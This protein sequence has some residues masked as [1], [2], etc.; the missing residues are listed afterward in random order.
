LTRA[1]AVEDMEIITAGYFSPTAFTHL[2]SGKD[3][4]CH[5]EF[6]HITR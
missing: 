2:R 4:S 5:C 6:V 3:S 1:K